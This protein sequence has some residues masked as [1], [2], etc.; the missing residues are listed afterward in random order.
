[1]KEDELVEKMAQK[2]KYISQ[3][4]KCKQHCIDCYGKYHE[5]IF[6]SFAVD[7]II[8]CDYRKQSDTAKEILQ[9]LYGRTRN[10]YDNRIMLTSNDIKDLAKEYGAEVEE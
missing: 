9:L 1:M 7:A 6:Y 4:E 3:D 8:V 5:C 2:M 10:G